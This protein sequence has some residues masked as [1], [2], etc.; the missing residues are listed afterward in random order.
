[1]TKLVNLAFKFLSCTDKHN[2]LLSV[3]E[4]CSEFA[5]RQKHL[6]YLLMF[7]KYIFICIP[8]PK[9][10]QGNMHIIPKFP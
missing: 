6:F 9:W 10:H 4:N 5:L 2:G 7:I 3:I 8:R 1:M